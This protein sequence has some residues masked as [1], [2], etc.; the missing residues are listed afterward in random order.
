MSLRF[1]LVALIVALVA[2]VA[3]ALSAFELDNLLE[4]LSAEALER[5]QLASQQVYA[6]LI[7]HINPQAA[8]SADAAATEAQWK[9]VSSPDTDKILLATLARWPSVV[10]INVADSNGRILASSTESRVGEPMRQLESFAAWRAHPVSQRIRD[11]LQTRPDLEVTVRIGAAGEN[12]PLFVIQVVASTVLLRE[13]LEP[14]ARRLAKESIAAVLASLVLTLLL[15]NLILGPVRR[16]E[17]TIDRIVQGSVVEPGRH[18]GAAKEFRAVENKLSLLGREYRGAR[19]DARQLRDRI[20]VEVERIASQLDVATRLAAISRLTGGVAH[21]IKNPLN[22]ILLR[23]DLLRERLGAPEE[24]LAGEIGILSKEVLRLDRVVKTFL[25][26][27]RPL[28]VRFQDVDL[29]ALAAE[30]ADLM[31]PQA[32]QLGIVVEFFAPAAGEVAERVSAAAGAVSVVPAPPV[33]ARGQAWMRGDADLLKQAVLNLV[34]NAMEAMKTGGRLTLRVDAGGN[35]VSLK[36]ADSG[37]GIPREVRPKVF[38]LYFTTKE[39]GS[40]IGLAMTYR[41]VQLHNGTIE[42]ES[43]SGRGTTFL[44][45][46]PARQAR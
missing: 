25:D 6:S 18:R 1:R 38:Q 40:G 10:E 15:T 44:L 46:F 35:Q 22:A 3:L 33:A 17:Q 34:T 30:V 36:V 41:A 12:R 21:E 13:G 2:L 23:L 39:R 27:S 29:A 11:V 5:S 42:F 14:Q 28:E 16:I 37:P 43:E 19:E 4:L 26:F 8:P 32:R 31:T 24:E 45:Q 7:E 9:L 20:D